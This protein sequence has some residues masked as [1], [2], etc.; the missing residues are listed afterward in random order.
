MLFVVFYVF[1]SSFFVF[2]HLTRDVLGTVLEITQNEAMGR[3][4]Y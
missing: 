1:L 2:F 4:L 3:P